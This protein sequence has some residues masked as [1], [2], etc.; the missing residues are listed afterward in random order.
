MWP[1]FEPLAQT[2]SGHLEQMIQDIQSSKKYNFSFVSPKE[3]FDTCNLNRLPAWKT[4]PES[5]TFPSLFH[6]QLAPG[7][8][9]GWVSSYPFH[10]KW[11]SFHWQ[12]L[13]KLM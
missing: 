11:D 5:R 6:Q 7:E 10:V 13:R 9:V 1:H 2:I 8:I 3:A 12:I 4:S